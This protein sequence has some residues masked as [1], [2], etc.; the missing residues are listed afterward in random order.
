MANVVKKEIAV[1]TRCAGKDPPNLQLSK[2][3][4]CKNLGSKISLMYCDTLCLSRCI[5]PDE[6][7]VDG[8]EHQWHC[9]PAVDPRLLKGC[10]TARHKTWRIMRAPD[11]TAASDHSA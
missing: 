7:S 2:I 5:T 6:V 11:E 10:L 4:M 3:R 8:T 9:E 1:F